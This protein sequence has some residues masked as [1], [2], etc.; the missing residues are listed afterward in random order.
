MGAEARA[1][2]VYDRLER[3]THAG[4]DSESVRFEASAALRRAVPFEAWC[5]P[6]ADPATLLVGRAVGMGFPPGD[7]GR[8]FEIEYQEA[9]FN[10]FELLAVGAGR[11][12]GLALSTGGD[13]ER[14]TRWR[15]IFQPLGLGDELRT[16][17]M[18]GGHCWGYLALHRDQASRPFNSS[19][20]AFVA[21]IS[22]LLADGLR[23]ALMVHEPEAAGPAQSPALVVLGPGVAI[24]GMT[25][26]GE[27]WLKEADNS[28]RTLGGPLPDVVYAV[29][30]RLRASREDSP[31]P[32]PAPRVRFRTRMGHWAV[33]SAQPLSARSGPEKVAVAFEPAKAE[34]L[35][36]LIARAYRLTKRERQLVGLVLR[37]LSTAE[38]AEC[39][40]ISIST[41]QDHAQAVFGKVGVRSRRELC[42]LVFGELN[43]DDDPM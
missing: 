13:L 17:L 2:A 27:R 40:R 10:K 41:V 26:A 23:D 20:V 6:T 22:P 38:L 8:A 18:S 16:A 35:A 28:A 1:A 30:A 33:V 36:P 37:G 15:D 25:P 4:L 11:A 5:A 12:A 39:M 43:M 9:D 19:E 24:D 21:R 32:A 3:L 7:A 14:S 29:V 42:S 34:D 31:N